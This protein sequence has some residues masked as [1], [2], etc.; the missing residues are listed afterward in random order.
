MTPVPVTIRPVDRT[1]LART[2]LGL[3]EGNDAQA[4]APVNEAI[5]DLTILELLGAS[6]KALYNALQVLMREDR[7]DMKQWCYDQMLQAQRDEEGM[8]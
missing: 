5:A 4:A 6:N 8:T 2:I 7:D 3:I 1:R